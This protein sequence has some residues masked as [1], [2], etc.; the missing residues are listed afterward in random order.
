MKVKIKKYFFLCLLIIQTIGFAQNNLFEAPNLYCVRNF[1]STSVVLAWNK[2]AIAPCFVAYDVYYKPENGNFSLLFSLNN[3]NKKDTTI[4]HP[5]PG[6][7]VYFYMTQRGSCI[8]SSTTKIYSDTLDSR[9]SF[10]SVEIKKVS[11]VNNQIELQWTPENYK[12]IKGYLIYSNKTANN[13]F[14][15]PIDTVFGNMIGT[16]TDSKV[17]VNDSQYSY[18]I[19]TLMTC[20]PDGAITLDKQIHTSAQLRVTNVNKCVASAGLEWKKYIFEDKDVLNYEVQTRTASTSFQSVDTLESSVTNYAVRNVAPQEFT[21]IRLKIN[22]PNGESA[23]SNEV[24]FFSETPIPI[25][26]DY[27]RWITVN[28]DSSV[29]IEYMKDTNA[30]LKTPINLETTTKINSFQR[31]GSSYY[32]QNATH[33]LFE[34][35]SINPNADAYFYRIEY[36][37]DCNN[38]LYS[39][40]VQTLHISAT[41]NTNNVAQINWKGFNIP[42]IDFVNYQ[43]YKITN[44][45][46]SDTVLMHTYS[47]QDVRKETDNKLFD[48]KNLELENVCY[49]IVANY[50]HLKDAQPRTLLQSKSN[51]FCKAPTPK[52]FI[53]NAFVPEGYNKTIKPFLLF[54][55]D[56]DYEW[57]VFNRWNQVVFKTNDINAAWDGYYKG[58]IAPFD[59]YTFVVTYTGKDNITYKEK[60]T[61]LLVR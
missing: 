54:A 32:S 14:N 45:L 18:K 47:A 42:N 9:L 19:R 38:E 25:E 34:D 11:V 35:K 53:P 22:L 31:A 55:I 20:D 58:E 50:Y 6:Q 52:F 4:N 13:Q 3:S 59:S 28:A 49:F 21:Y 41:E 36:R 30:V 61:F 40:T 57:I 46:A 15:T 1:T 17:N 10:P 51:Y 44:D 7:T 23:Y 26:K 39:D 5:N 37:D 8:N 56:K 48:T 29:S 16:Y 12:E 2:P 33:L 60:G 27:I 43:L 24:S